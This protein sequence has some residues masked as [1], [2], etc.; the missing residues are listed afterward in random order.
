MDIG[1]TSGFLGCLFISLRVFRYLQQSI[2]A[3][4]SEAGGVEQNLTQGSP[5]G[6]GTDTR[7]YGYVLS[8]W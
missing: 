2:H 7:V 8:A 5:V 6:S 1:C 3:L 4:G